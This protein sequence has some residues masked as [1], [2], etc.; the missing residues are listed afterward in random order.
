MKPYLQLIDITTNNIFFKYFE[1]EF[2]RD[3]FARKLK[4]SK[5]IRIIDSGY[6]E[7]YK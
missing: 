6:K 1:T 7:D 5:K 4:F 2:E 3:K